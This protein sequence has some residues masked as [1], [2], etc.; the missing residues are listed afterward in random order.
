MISSSK[1]PLLEL[2]KMKKSKFSSKL[3]EALNFWR[4]LQKHYKIG[5]ILP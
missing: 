3:I 2:R 1:K 4:P 5:E